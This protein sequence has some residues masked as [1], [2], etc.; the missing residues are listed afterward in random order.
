MS[1]LVWLPLNGSLKNIGLDKLSSLTSHSVTYEDGKI[2][3][4]LNLNGVKSA[5]GTFESVAGLKVFSFSCWFKVNS[6]QTYSSWADCLALGAKSDGIKTVHRIEHTST[7]GA[8]QLIFGKSANGGS[9]KNTYYGIGSSTTLAT[10]KWLHIVVTNDG[11]KVRTYFNGELIATNVISN[12]YSD[13]W[14]TGEVTLGNSGTQGCLN[15]LRI[16]DHCLSLKEIKEISKGL[17]LHYPLRDDWYENTTNILTYPTP[18]SAVTS[19]SWDTTKHIDAINVSGWSNGYN[20]SVS[21][22]A[23]GYHAHWKLIDGVPTIVFPDRNSEINKAHR[24]LGIGMGGYQSKVGAG[25]TYTI[26]F[27][28]RAD[29]DGMLVRSGYHYRNSGAS[30]NNFN[31]GF[32][33]AYVTNSWKRYSKT[34]TTKSTMDTSVT[35][36]F[37]FYGH[38]G[39]KEGTSY[40]RN[41][42]VEVKDHATAYVPTSRTVTSICDCSGYGN[43]GTISGSLIVTDGSARCRKSTKFTGSQY[44]N[45]GRG[46][47]VKDAITVSMWA[48]MDN[49]S[50]YTR[51]ISCTEGGGWNFEPASN[52]ASTGTI[53]VAMGT[54]TTANAYKSVTG[55]K[56]WKDLAAGWHMFTTTYDG[57]A[58]KLYLDGELI[59][60]NSAYTTHTPIYYNASN[61]IFI[62]AEAG[63]SAT[64]PVGSYFN[65]KLSDVR[66]YATAL[67]ANDI[68]ALYEAP[69]SID[70]NG[71][72][73]AMEFE[74]G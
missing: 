12:I 11:E 58:T 42:Q 20:G 2:G 39:S 48:Y 65:G 1:L 40:V 15:D 45:V 49:W 52:N 44:I 23:T 13:G 26:S 14:L 24:W 74:E 50:T 51:M 56:Y 9:N 28:A 38:Y 36:T 43:D 21:Y 35:A 7:T 18:G 10:D 61:S 69:I 53:N 8:F 22:P 33:D 71:D 29:V 68:K 55:S 32:L 16:Y 60:T 70:K 72:V 6:A 59:G 54:G 5:S 46:A 34:F 66:I 47:M 19:S 64:T 31:D 41:V 57:F 3:K 25:V 17:I 37:Y 30:S 73:F 27:D 63:S 62:G 4:C 67:S